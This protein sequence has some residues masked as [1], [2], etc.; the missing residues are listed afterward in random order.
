MNVNLIEIRDLWFAYEETPVLLDVNLNLGR[1]DFLALIGP[2]GGGKTTLMKLMLGLLEP[3]S[4]Q[5]ERHY[6]Q[7]GY[8][9]QDA[10]RNKGFPITVADVV[11]LG[12]KPRLRK[13]AADRARIR[14]NL[15]RVGLADCAERRIDALSGGQRQRVMIARALATEPEILFLDEP[16]A[17]VD[18]RGQ[19]D[20]YEL[21]AELNQHLTIVLISHDFMAVSEHVKQVACVNTCVHHHQGGE[22]SA[23]I[24]EQ[25]YCCPVDLVAHGLPHRV[26]ARHEGHDHD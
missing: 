3:T 8:V 17:S 6:R 15:A 11:G 9:P 5:I 13:S 12:L 2:N 1:G 24:L 20:L 7:A 10:N 21:L 23:E 25:A 18:L 16:T 14:E 4:G 19:N 26:F 22:L